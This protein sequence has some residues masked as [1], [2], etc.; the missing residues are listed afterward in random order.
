MSDAPSRLV[1]PGQDGPDETEVSLRPSSLDE[2]V[3]QQQLRDNL[4]VFIEAARSRREALDHVLL[5][6]PPGLG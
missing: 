4:R 6:G 2:F 1:D 3:G 5:S